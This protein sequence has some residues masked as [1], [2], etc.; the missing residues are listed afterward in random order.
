MTKQEKP[1]KVNVEIKIEYLT[2]II[3]L[4][5]DESGK[6]YARVNVNG[7]FQNK[8]IMSKQFSSYVRKT[9]KTQFNSVTKKNELEEITSYLDSLAQID[10]K[11]VKPEIR[12]CEKDDEIF[13]DYGC[14]D[15]N[16]IKI[17]ATNDNNYKE[18]SYVRNNRSFPF[19]I[20]PSNFQNLP[21][22]NLKYANIFKLK[23]YLNFA[24]ESDFYLFVIALSYCFQRSTPD[25]IMILNGPQGS[26]KSTTTLLT[27][28]LL[29]PSKAPLRSMPKNEEDLIIAVNNNFLYAID[30]IS[31]L[32]ASMADSLCRL[33]TGGGIS[34][35]K[36][37]TDSDEDI[38]EAQNPIIINGINGI[39]NR[40]DLM[41][42]SIIFDLAPIDSKNYKTKSEIEKEF[43]SDIPYI[44]GGI[45]Q[46]VQFALNRYKKA[47]VLKKSRMAD[48]MNWGAACEEY[49]KMDSGSFEKCYNYKMGQTYKELSE[50]SEIVSF[51]KQ[52]FLE[53]FSNDNGNIVYKKEALFEGTMTE[54]YEEM[55]SLFIDNRGNINRYFKQPNQLS[56][57][58]NREIKALEAIGFY[59]KMTKSDSRKVLIYFNEVLSSDRPSNFEIEVLVQKYKDKDP[60]VYSDET[61]NE[62]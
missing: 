45:L 54:L 23:K 21:K 55:K 30:N 39:S 12:C 14:T 53:E 13:F 22:P 19:F 9:I 29:D 32:K 18:I 57:A 34:R 38:L 46:L 49:L 8:R 51:F 10:G 25:L 61:D 16:L 28:M 11:K 60:D 42:R 1:Q 44:L 58:I 33:S 43:S 35:R 52:H 15:W 6:S 62:W 20:R 24:E 4:F 36:K 3:E 26:A 48:F 2:N 40:Q 47:K 5:R 7:S 59:V 37:Y 41:S 17:T 27:K 31:S 56:R 50:G